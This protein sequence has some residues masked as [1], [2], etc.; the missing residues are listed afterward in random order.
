VEEVAAKTPLPPDSQDDGDGSGSG[1]G[2][3]EG[4]EASLSEVEGKLVKVL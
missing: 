4:A 1:D 2:G 3:S